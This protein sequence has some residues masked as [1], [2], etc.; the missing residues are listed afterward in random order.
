[1]DERQREIDFTAAELLAHLGRCG[2]SRVQ[3]GLVALVFMEGEVRVEGDNKFRLLRMSSRNA[4]TRLRSTS[5]GVV[6]AARRVEKMGLVRIVREGRGR[7]LKYIV[8]L[9]AVRSLAPRDELA[10]WSPS[11][12]VQSGAKW[13]KVVQSPPLVL[14]ERSLKNSCPPVPVLERGSVRG[15]GDFALCT[16]HRT[17]QPTWDER[18]LPWSKASGFTDAE[19]VAAV[20]GRDFDWLAHV[21]E[22]LIVA[23]YLRAR[24][25]ELHPDGDEWLRFL[26]LAHHAAHQRAYR[27][28]RAAMQG[29]IVAGRA[30]GCGIDVSRTSIAD[31]EWARTVQAS[32]WRDPALAGRMMRA[33]DG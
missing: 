30:Q 27:S 14:G 25:V 7:P 33:E 22:Q 11:D 23:G 24:S 26:T 10:D 32:Y 6:D 29:A 21:Y 28:K 17:L 9:L 19:L 2:L 31:E 5:P 12:Q 18:R 15:S 16:L 4:A 13:C 1:M 8:D 3:A 20:A